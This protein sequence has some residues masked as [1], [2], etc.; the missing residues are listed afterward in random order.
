MVVNDT[1][2]SEQMDANDVESDVIGIV[3]HALAHIIE[4][5][6]VYRDRQSD[7]PARCSLKPCAWALWCR[8]KRRQR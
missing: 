7:S 1:D 8:M 3:L 6:I 2:I 4:R 5:P